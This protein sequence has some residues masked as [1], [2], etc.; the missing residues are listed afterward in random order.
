MIAAITRYEILTRITS[1]ETELKSILCRYNDVIAASDM[2]D[3]SPVRGCMVIKPWG[4]GVWDL[5]RYIT[6]LVVQLQF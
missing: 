2:M 4:M 6:F 1:Y 3:A 5:L